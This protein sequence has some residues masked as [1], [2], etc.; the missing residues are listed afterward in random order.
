MW[1]TLVWAHVYAMLSLISPS[2]S[3]VVVYPDRSNPD[4]RTVKV[5]AVAGQRD[6]RVVGVKHE[7]GDG[8]GACISGGAW[9]EH[10]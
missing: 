5:S 4:I 9:D 3:Q 7:I 2:C 6:K 1:D 10:D 8:S